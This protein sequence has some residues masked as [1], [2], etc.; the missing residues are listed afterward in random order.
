MMAAAAAI[1]GLAMAGGLLPGAT[2]LIF[3]TVFLITGA[4]NA[5][6]DYYDRDIDAWISIASNRPKI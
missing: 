1:V 3:L 6:N 2:A 4:G 5:I